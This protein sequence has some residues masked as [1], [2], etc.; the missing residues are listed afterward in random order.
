MKG[1]RKGQNKIELKSGFLIF[2]WKGCF[3]EKAQGLIGI[4]GKIQLLHTHSYMPPTV[5]LI[6]IYCKLFL[7]L[8]III[9]YSYCIQ[10]IVFGNNDEALVLIPWKGN[11]SPN[12][13]N[14][15][16]E[17]CYT[18]PPKLSNPNKY[19][20]EPRKWVKI[21]KTHKIVL[22]INKVCIWLIRNS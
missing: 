3:L 13:H 6:P 22:N 16:F 2:Y 11:H 10:F 18:V 14:L 21:F 5:Q 1:E 15:D 4:W 20:K 7:C 17:S 8:Y 9:I 12:H 19:E